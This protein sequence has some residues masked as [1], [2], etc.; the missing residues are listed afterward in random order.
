MRFQL[1]ARH[2]D[3]MLAPLE[4]A[5][6]CNLHI[7]FRGNVLNADDL[8][9]WTD[10]Q[11]LCDLL[12]HVLRGAEEE[13]AAR[14]RF[15]NRPT[16]IGSMARQNENCPAYCHNPILLFFRRSAANDLAVLDQDTVVDDG[17]CTVF[18]GDP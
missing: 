7:F 13:D 4:P 12:H 14:G 1:N 6:L 18:L 10:A 17:I 2:G 9:D 8:A 16:H 11:G 5:V 15:L 3:D